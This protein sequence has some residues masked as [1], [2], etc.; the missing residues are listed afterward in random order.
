MRVRVYG[1]KLDLADELQEEF[2]VEARLVVAEGA[3]ILLAESQR[4]IAAYGRGPAP[5]GSTPG[6]VTGNL[7]K[8]TKLGTVRQGRDRRSVSGAV[9]YAPHA[10]LVEYGH[11]NV[12]GTR[13]LP[14]PFIRP[15][16]EAAEPQ[17]ERLF[18]E[19]L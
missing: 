15:A 17:V 6:T 16:L 10:H 13:T 2:I 18:R 8:M 11:D 19:K 3:R 12:D 9:R 4:K 14:R 1:D 5:A 7:L